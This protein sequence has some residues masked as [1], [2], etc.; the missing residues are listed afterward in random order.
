MVFPDNS[1]NIE[2]YGGLSNIRMG[3]YNSNIDVA[4]E[5]NES[6]G[7]NSALKNVESGL[8]PEI[9]IYY[10]INTPSLNFGLYLKNQFIFVLNSSG[11]AKWDSGKSAQIVDTDFNVLYSGIGGRLS[12]SNAELPYLTGFI[13]VDG[14][15]CYYFWNKMYEELNK[16]N[17]ENIYTINKQWTT[18]IPGMNVEAGIQWMLSETFGFGLKGGY[19]LSAGSVTVKINNVNGWTGLNES[20]DNVD[21]SGF[22]GGAGMIIK[23][24]F[25]NKK[26]TNDKIDKNTKFPGLSGWLYNEAKSFYDE[27]LYK[28]AREKILEA[29]KIDGENE[30]V[31]NLKKQIDKELNTENTTEKI[32]KLLKQ[33]DEYK[34]KKQ[35]RN[36]R[37]LYNEVI[38]IDESN[39]QAQF[40]LSEF[41]TKAMEEFNK[42]NDFMKH[43]KL[44][45]ALKSINLA[46]EYGIGKEGEDLKSN[47]E[48]K[49]NKNKDRDNLYNDGVDKY[50]KGEYEEAI[51]KWQ[52]VL[53]I[54]PFDKEAENNVKK[55]TEKIKEKN[56]EENEEIKKS[57]EEAK[58][59]YSIGN[60]DAAMEKCEYVMR[61][62][63]DNPECKKI[64]EEIKKIQEENK[65]EII[66]KR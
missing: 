56:K 11:V 39:K 37:K 4:N 40:Y 49:I 45:D 61:L 52:M 50:R 63:P 2:I 34:F 65:V 48:G 57:I 22:Y 18:I 62:S 46:I 47:I 27:G 16:E 28:Q 64:M 30:M 66:K 6:L 59:F 26:D 32:N 43:N 17:G 20:E 60:F 3:N 5:K 36:A 54:D 19:R 29:E 44:K 12:I 41:E 38:S 21:Y 24:N 10:Q 35:F 55:A 33:A 9:N 53:Q 7:I 51:K 23:F 58:K 1:L 25:Q 31:I 14:G 8:A 13:G 42:A 15:I